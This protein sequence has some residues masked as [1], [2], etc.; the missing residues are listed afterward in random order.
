MWFAKLPKWIW[1]LKG[2]ENFKCP[3]ATNNSKNRC[4]Q[5]GRL[6]QS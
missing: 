6:S 4:E 1:D 2:S 5:T 3:E